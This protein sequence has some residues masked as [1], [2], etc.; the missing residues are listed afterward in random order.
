MQREGAEDL[1]QEVLLVVHEKY[2]SLDRVEDLLPLSLQI[3]RFK[4]VAAR[5]KIAQRSENTQ[6]S[7]DDLP[8]AGG[9]P[10]P[11]DETERRER[12]DRLESILSSLG[13][14]CRELMRLKLEGYSFP[15]IQKRLQAG[16]LNTLYTWDFRC[17][18][19]IR[20]RWNETEGLR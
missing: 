1:A 5:R 2:G 17:R 8:I 18:A 12:L 15:E 14:R 10:D 13:A 3:A 7:L 9:A 11:F 19:E 20:T 6:V 4:I 16:S